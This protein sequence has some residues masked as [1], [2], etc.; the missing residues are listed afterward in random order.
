MALYDTCIRRPVFATMLIMALVV[1]GVFSFFGLGLDLF[2]K[3]DLPTITVLTTFRGAAPEEIEAQVTKPLEEAINTISGIDELRSTSFEGVSQVI[4]VFKLE[5]DADVASQEVRDR[6]SRI[7]S[8]LPVGVD[9]SI[10]Q[11]FDPDAAPILVVAVSGDM[12]I[13]TV[14][15]LAKKRV[16]EAL[17]SV[18]GV[19]SVEIVGGREREIRLVLDADKL[20]AYQIPVQQIVAALQR[21]NV[22]IPGGRVDQGARELTLRTVGR[23]QTPEA[24]AEIV[25]ARRGE[26]AAAAE[27]RV[28]DLGR[29][30][31]DEEEARNVARFDGRPAVSVVV[32]KQSGQNTVEVVKRVSERLEEIRPSLPP[33]LR[34]EIVRNQADFIVN[35]IHEVY[36]HLI[37][38]G[39]LAALT[40]WVFMRDW[41]STLIAGLA[42]PVSLIS[43]FT[44]MKAMGFTLNNMT[45]LGL[46]IAVGIVIDDAL[47]VL[48][49]IFRH[50]DEEGQPPL[51]AAM[52]GTAEISLAVM[53][54]TLSLVVIFL[55]IGFMGGIVGRFLSSFGLTVAFA[56]MVSLLV[57]FT[58]TP[59]LCSRML[60][61]SAVGHSAHESRLNIAI[62]SVYMKLLVWALAHRKTVALGAMLVI[63]STIPAFMLVGKD[64]FPADD[65]SEFEITVTAPEGWSLARSEELLEELEARVRDF[66]EVSHILSSIGEGEGASVG[67]IRLYVRMTPLNTRSISQFEVMKMARALLA[68]HPELRGA[69]QD[70]SAISGGGFRAQLVNV[71]LRGPSLDRLAEFTGRL[72]GSLRSI[73]ELV[74]LDST[75]KIG[76]PEMRVRIDRARAADLG[77][78]ARD[79][80]DAMRFLVGGELKVS[81]FRE[82][83]E[84]YDVKLRAEKADRSLASTIAAL[85]VPS[86]V[87]LVPLSSVARVEEGTG[88]TQIDR[89]NR[90]RQVTLLANLA[91]GATLGDAVAKIEKEAGQLGLPPGYSVEFTGRAKTLAESNRNFALAF[92]LSFIFMYMVLAAQFESFINPIIILLS[93]PLSVPFALLSLVVGGMSL[94]IYSILGLFMLFG[95]VK[96]NGIL[97]IDYTNTLRARGVERDKAILE[98]NRARLRPILMTTITLVLGMVPLALGRG[99]GSAS[100]ATMAVAIIG[101]Q[102]LSLF[103]TLV[104]TPVAYAWFDD[105]AQAWERK[106]FGRK[107]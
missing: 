23:I 8:Q 21:E 51:Q 35:S 27:I 47:V 54:T 67:D 3:I 60:G 68:E 11:K 98:A 74:D 84:V 5:K 49:N 106:L 76:K 104:V 55:P 103:I 52:T 6:V 65:Q 38:G 75:L 2:P 80:A 53:A 13:R 95:V 100:R 87:G 90:Q 93:L 39:L 71:N 64:F 41:R 101:G 4:V 19:G 26:G 50:I 59:M 18:S 37:L 91:P 14:T 70:V 31:D 34:A 42:I 85:P 82:G 89:Q 83:D 28:R 10:I 94:N 97:Q 44:L 96:K 46:T 57:S 12:P 99:P 29:V 72:L 45:L 1:V 36:V 79:I 105:L 58:L 25:V 107:A 88:P 92:A 24:F 102:A 56:I 73:P 16:K 48:E 77:V 62:Q 7:Q 20:T 15:E 9:A 63:L 30:L 43:T 40:T 69:V 61:A 33:G 22:E 78:N 32:R 81:E 86:N 17:E 66:P